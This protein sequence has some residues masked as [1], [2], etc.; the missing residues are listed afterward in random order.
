MN[1]K[2]P[3]PATR[4]GGFLRRGLGQAH[5]RVRRRYGMRPG[6]LFPVWFNFLRSPRVER[7]WFRLTLRMMARSA[8]GGVRDLY[9]R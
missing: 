7:W 6:I 5:V 1:L 2:L 8:V 3:G 9:L 4:S